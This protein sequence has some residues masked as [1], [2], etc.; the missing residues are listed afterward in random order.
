MKSP[1]SANKIAGAV[2]ELSIPMPM[3]GNGSG[4]NSA[5][6]ISLYFHIPFC[7]KKC[8][9]CHFYVLPNK[10]PLHKL[11]MEGLILNLERWAPSLLGK[12][13]A[14]IYFGGGTPA[15]LGADNIHILL[16]KVNALLP[17]AKNEIEITL[18]AN[19]ETI[20]Y[21][22]MQEYAA[23]GVNRLSI[24]IQSLDNNLLT[25]LGRSHHAKQAIQAVEDSFKAGL[26]N[27]SIDLMYDIPGQ[28]LSSWKYTVK[29]VLHLPITHLSLY[30]LTIEPETVFFKYRES[31]QK[32]LPDAE[33]SADMYSF[34]VE[35]LAKA[36]LNQ[37]EISAFA[38]NALYSRHNVGYW[39]A[40]PFLGLGPSAFSYW[41]GR[42]FRAV[43]NIQRYIQAL[44]SDTKVEDFSEILP[45][46]S[47]RRELLAIALRLLKGVDLA[48]FQATHGILDAE[49][50]K[51]LKILE[52]QGFLATSD[53]SAIQLTGKGILFY[54]TVA[55]DLI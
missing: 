23:V 34:A 53:A 17:Y 47:R 36:G 11:L 2:E 22:L 52:E 33:S 49:T 55:S 1:I 25:K 32:D 12:K 10:A 45:S 19:P 24:G 4:N 48:D 37:Y 15:L 7:T 51:T 9:Y 46:L 44:R 3:T 54:D 41:E 50:L 14:S 5:N 38:K 18:E 20:T 16:E 21:A 27:L 8:D 30:N 31:L 26:A 29:E 43:A 39:T 6:A 35:N 42:R 28:T 40:R 13:L